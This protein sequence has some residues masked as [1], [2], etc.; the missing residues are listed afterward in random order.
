MILC[1]KKYRGSC[2]IRTKCQVRLSYHL[3]EAV[4]KFDNTEAK[5]KLQDFLHKELRRPPNSQ[6]P[7]DDVVPPVG[8]GGLHQ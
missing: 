6:L 5:M 1:M 2:P 8:V 3:R 7:G 4:G